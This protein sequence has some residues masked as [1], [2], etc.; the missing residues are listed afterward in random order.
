MEGN[1]KGAD[2]AVRAMDIPGRPLFRRRQVSRSFLPIRGPGSGT[3]TATQRTLVKASMALGVC[4]SGLAS[5]S[6]A[7]PLTVRR[8]GKGSRLAS[9]LLTLIPILWSPFGASTSS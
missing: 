4:L 6:A 7:L 1:L 3:Y 8:Q 5:P 2:G 9:F